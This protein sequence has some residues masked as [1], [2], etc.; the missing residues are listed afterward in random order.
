MAIEGGQGHGNN[1]N[2]AHGRAFV[3]EA[4]EARQDP[5]IMTGMF[6]L[7]NHYATT[8]FDSGADYSFVS[9]TFIPLL[10]M[11]P[12]N[13]GMD[14]LS[15]HKAEI[16]F[17]KKLVRI[18]LPHGEMLKVLGERPEKKAKHLVSAKAEG[19]KL[20]DIFVV[21][22]FSRVFPDDLSGLPPS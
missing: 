20:K 10:D 16:V 1:G 3:M 5:N 22:N 13:L 15:R 21:R 17:Q 19:Q 8:L 11:E 4:E 9:T 12:S 2:Q 7:N 18:T 14:W 6:T